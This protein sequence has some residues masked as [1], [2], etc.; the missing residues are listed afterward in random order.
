M[1]TRIL[2]VVAVVCALAAYHFYS[3]ND[4]LRAQLASA[5]APGLERARHL[6]AE[7]MDGQGAEIERAMAWLDGFYKSADGLQRPEGLWIDGHPDY[8]G[9]SAWIFDV[10]LRNRLRGQTE[11]QARARVEGAIKQS[12]EWRTKHRAQG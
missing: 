1:L 7:S 5:Q 2:A 8:T 4:E 3:Q 12:E 10:Y 9:I 11:E 6:T